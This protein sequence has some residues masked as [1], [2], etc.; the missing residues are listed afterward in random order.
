MKL[1]NIFLAFA[2][3]CSACVASANVVESPEYIVDNL[4]KEQRTLLIHAYNIGK[5]I[6]L[7]ETMQV[8]LFQ[9]SLAGKLGRVNTG[10][11]KVAYGVTQV[12]P[13]TAAEVINKYLEGKIELEMS[14]T[15]RFQI[16]QLDKDERVI[17][18][19]LKKDDLFALFVG[20]LVLKEY[21]SQTDNW[22]QMVVSYYEGVN[23][24]RRFDAKQI[25][26]HFYFQS[27]REKLE[28]VRLFNQQRTKGNSIHIAAKS[29]VQYAAAN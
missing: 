10:E 11:V 26:S 27:I 16:G 14:H 28:V 17:Q 9:E 23:G 7:P 29:G 12:K 21:Q 19:R 2:F 8:I 15:L 18:K 3:M 6:D 20:A 13:S 4:T 24:S 22:R 25:E 1:Q 5:A